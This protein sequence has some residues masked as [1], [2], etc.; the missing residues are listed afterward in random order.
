MR[1][2][3]I[4]V[5]EDNAPDVWMLETALRRAGCRCEITVLR[6]GV[7]AREFVENATESPAFIVLDLNVPRIDGLAL[8]RVI[9]GSTLMGATE[10]VV[11]SSTAS[12]QHVAA[13]QALG[14]PEIVVKSPHAT[15][16]IALAEK[17]V[18]RLGC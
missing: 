7:Q 14:V 17:I 16:W 4:L 6:D 11:W 9:R 12:P 13:V 8:L 5:I 1:A 3:P 18:K 2:K 10:I 15:D